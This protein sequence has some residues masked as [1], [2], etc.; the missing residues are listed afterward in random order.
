V[1]K[2]L[3]LI[4]VM[5]LSA[6]VVQP[7]QGSETLQVVG[8]NHDCEVIA[9]VYGEGPAGKNKAR[10]DQGAFNQ[11]RN[12]AAAAGANAI[13][14]EDTHSEIWGSMVLA[15]AL[16]CSQGQFDQVSRI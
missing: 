12:R 7:K 5:A 14:L 2:L 1:N 9:K 6:C 15:E 10:A 13:H 8:E 4:P 16:F 3:A 11:V